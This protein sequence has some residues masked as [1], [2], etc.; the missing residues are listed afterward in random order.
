MRRRDRLRRRRSRRHAPLQS[1][2][3]D[4]ANGSRIV[5][6]KRID[7]PQLAAA[8]TREAEDSIDELGIAHRQRDAQQL[9][10]FRLQRAQF[11]RGDRMDLRRVEVEFEIPLSLRKLA[12]RRSAIPRASNL[13]GSGGK[14][15]KARRLPFSMRNAAGIV[16]AR[17]WRRS[18]TSRSTTIRRNCG[19]GVG[20]E[21]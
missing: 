1:N 11:F 14:V 15:S 13:A 9:P 20:G 18:E 19:P 8:P 6:K 4:F 5:R 16:T 2:C 17:P 10:C 21:E 7:L 3:V 12:L